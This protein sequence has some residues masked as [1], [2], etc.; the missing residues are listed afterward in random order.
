MARV[1]EC[2]AKASPSSASGLRLFGFHVS[3][4]NA[5][6]GDAGGG[7]RR[8][9]CQYCCR[10]FANSQA[11]GGHQ[12]AHKKERQQLRRRTLL[13]RPPPTLGNLALCPRSDPLA[14]ANWVVGYAPPPYYNCM[15]APA[16]RGGRAPL[17]RWCIDEDH[18]VARGAVVGEDSAQDIMGLD[19]Q[20]SLA[21][22]GS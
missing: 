19:L 14:A 22:A 1:V 16:F 20:L 15:G 18:T 2:R 12:N 8:F 10:E 7:G 4:N 3:D 6:A 17:I 13:H 21:P 9:E 5:A 11:L